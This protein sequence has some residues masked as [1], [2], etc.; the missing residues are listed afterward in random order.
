MQR[1]SSIFNNVNLSAVL[2]SLKIAFAPP[3]VLSDFAVVQTQYFNRRG[4]KIEEGTCPF[5]EKS[6][7]FRHPHPVITSPGLGRVLW[8]YGRLRR[9]CLYLC[10]R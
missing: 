2:D 4:R 8:A 5:R 1:I 6:M 7:V 3:A 9:P 10:H